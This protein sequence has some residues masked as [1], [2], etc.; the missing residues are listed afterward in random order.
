M[1]FVSAAMVFGAHAVLFAY[2]A[3]AGTAEKVGGLVGQGGFAGVTFFFILS[4]FVL[5]WSAKSSDRFQ[6]FW[7]RRFWKIYPSYLVALVGGILFAIAFQGAIQDPV[8]AQGAVWNPGRAIADA[9]L[10]QSWHPDVLVRTSF[11]Q[12]LWSLSAEAFFYLCFP[13]LLALITRVRTERLWA[14]T[15]GVVLAI[16]AVPTIANYLPQGTVYPN[17]AMTGTEVWLDIHFAGTRILD[18]ILGIFLARLVMAGKRMPVGL[19]G[20]VAIAVA[21]YFLSSY[22][23]LRYGVTAFMVVPLALVIATGAIRDA[24]RRPS[25][26]A[27]RVWVWLG[28]ISYAFYL[29]HF[30]VLM[31]AR[32]VLGTR[33]L[34]SW[35][36][37]GL[38]VLL[39]AI[40]IVVSAALHHG[41]ERPLMD[42]F[43]RSRREKQEA[44]AARLRPAPESVESD[45][46][47]ESGRR[48]A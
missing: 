37:T 35:A 45:L 21:A 20:A 42:R 16:F 13:V 43:S 39:F 5:T 40:T 17:F 47:I 8:I 11:N 24:E 19:G 26:L 2:F 25:F 29:L 38:L 18:F 3:N 31:L 44:A 6:S 36:G 10:V 48:A 34:G 30:L 4:G 15:G 9:L 22:V 46:D 32:Q 12:P 41:V 7:R 1:R 27:G 23:P 14:W 33:T 28:D